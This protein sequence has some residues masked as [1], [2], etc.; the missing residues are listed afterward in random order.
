MPVRGLVA[1]ASEATNQ[2]GVVGEGVGGVDQTTEH[3]VIPGGCEAELG[4]DRLF[5]R[6]RVAPPFTLEGEE[7]EFTVRQG[8]A[9][10]LTAGRL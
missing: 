10:T 9:S 2:H 3:L 4:A 7:G 6:P 5:F 1:T 8:H